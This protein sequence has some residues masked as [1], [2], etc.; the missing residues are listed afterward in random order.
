MRKHLPDD[1]LDRSVAVPVLA[2]LDEVGVLSK[3]TG[4]KE[5][6]YVVLLAERLRPADVGHRDGLAAPGVVGDGEHDEG[7]V[8]SV[9]VQEGRQPIEIHVALERVLP[10]G[11]VARLNDEV[12]RLGARRL[13]VG[14]RGVEVRVAW[15]FGVGPRNE[16][17]KNALGGTTLMSGNHVLEG[18]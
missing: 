7:H 11:I 9:L 14:P 13:D 2:L 10:L 3:P 15:D 8:R 12:D 1:L 5:E 6:R 17:H 16:P 4:V 18:H